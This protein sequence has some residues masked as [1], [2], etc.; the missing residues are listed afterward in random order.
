MDDAQLIE[1]IAEHIHDAWAADYPEPLPPYAVAPE[2]R[3]AY[4]R[5]A[6]RRALTG[7]ARAG[8]ILVKDAGVRS[9]PTT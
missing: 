8:Y 3:K 5:T 6:A 1:E 9:Y 2:Q 7:I 4:V